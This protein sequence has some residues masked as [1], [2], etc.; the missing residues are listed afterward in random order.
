MYKL[1]VAGDQRW[2]LVAI[3]GSLVIFFGVS[4]S[5]RHA[6]TMTDHGVVT[7]TYAAS[8][9][10]LAL[11]LGLAMAYFFKTVRITSPGS[12]G[13][14]RPIR[15]WL[16]LILFFFISLLL[17]KL[18]V[19]F[20]MGFQPAQLFNIALIALSAGIFEETLCRGLLF[21]FFLGIFQ[22]KNQSLLWTAVSSSLVFGLL[23]LSHLFNGQSVQT[24]MQQ[25]FYAFVIGMAFSAIRISTN[26]IW[27]G[28]VIHSLID[29]DPTITAQMQGNGNWAAAVIIFTPLLLISLVYLV[30]ANTLIDHRPVLKLGQ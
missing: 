9:L 18:G 20:S 7:L 28:L 2:K 30:K 22:S 8:R 23:H 4:N 21:S 26:G 14:Q 27:V 16:A 25:V 19:I 5:L 29:F 11:V 3:V 17:V 15:T 10:I 1:K 6:V 13:Y 12:I 24:T